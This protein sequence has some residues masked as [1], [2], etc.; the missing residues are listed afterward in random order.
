MLCCHTTEAF[1]IHLL[2][3]WEWS[4]VLS[5]FLLIPFPNSQHIKWIVVWTSKCYQ[6]IPSVGGPWCEDGPPLRPQLG[7][8]L[9][10]VL[11]LFFWFCF[12]RRD[13]GFGRSYF[14]S[15]PTHQHRVLYCLLPIAPPP[16]LPLP[17]SCLPPLDLTLRSGYSGL[18]L[19][20]VS[21]LFLPTEPS[22][23]SLPSSL[24]LLFLPHHHHRFP[25]VDHRLSSD[26]SPWKSF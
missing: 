22:P 17:L 15:P 23:K 16:L 5:W 9:G 7:M 4:S 13:Q 3:F 25:S 6:L 2:H 21:S 10:F 1:Q 8:W 19:P 26:L 18:A 14:R 24:I 20:F 12:H 11:L